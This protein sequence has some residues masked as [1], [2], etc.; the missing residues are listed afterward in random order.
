MCGK[1]LTAQSHFFYLRVYFFLYTFCNCKQNRQTIWLD[2]YQNNYRFKTRLKINLLNWMDS[3]STLGTGGSGLLPTTCTRL[4]VFW[5]IQH[6]YTQTYM[7]HI[8][9]TLYWGVIKI[10]N[11]LILFRTH[12]Y[13]CLC[14]TLLF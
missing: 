3:S 13:G 4:M 9:Y 14:C 1:L 5:S 2:F 11:N 12:K 7:Y 6:L 8:Y 10:M